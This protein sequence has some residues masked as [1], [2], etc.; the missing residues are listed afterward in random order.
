[1]VL[2]LSVTCTDGPRRSIVHVVGS[3][4][5]RVLVLALVLAVLPAVPAAAQTCPDPGGAEM[6]APETAAGDFSIGGHGWGHGVG[7]SQY[8]AY[9]A[10]TLGCTYTEI[11]SAYYPGTSLATEDET[12]TIRIRLSGLPGET[13]TVTAL[14]G[15]VEWENPD[16]SEETL[17]E[18]AERTVEMREAGQPPHRIHLDG[19]RVSLSGYAHTYKRGT[20]EIYPRF[21]TVAVLDL[22][23]YL[24]GLAEVPKLW[25]SDTLRAQVIAGRTYALRWVRTKGDAWQTDSCRCHI[26]DTPLHQAY[27]GASHE[28]GPGV[29]EWLAAVHGTA[30]QVLRYEGALIQALYSSSH[31]GHSVGNQ[32]RWGTDQLPYLAP[33][34]DSRWELEVSNPNRVWSV[35]VSAERLGEIADVGTAVSAQVTDTGPGGRIARLR[36]E[37]S[38]GGADL[39]GVQVQSRLG[40]R[41]IPVVVEGGADPEEVPPGAAEACP[42]D[43]VPDGGF[44]DIDGN[45]HEAA[46]NCIVE[47]GLTQ[48]LGDGRYGPGLA[49]TRD[50][51]ASFIA[52]LVEAAGYELPEPSDQGFTDIDGNTHAE[53]IN[54]LAAVGIVQGTTETSY[55]PRQEVRRDQMASFLVRAWETVTGEPLTAS[56]SHFEDTADSIHAENIDKAAEA[57]FARGVEEGRYAPARSVR[58][59]QMASFLARVLDGFV[60]TGHAH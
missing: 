1:M 55:S 10:A 11:L 58:R 29:A 31:G 44:D 49:V 32:F 51:M 3:T 5:M 34:D 41:A 9:G 4:P 20:I 33:V 17:D 47:W 38:A 21:T 23:E 19:T 30:G 24:Y 39:T 54:Q 60:A 6:P 37:G 27:T 40:L 12:E 8:G 59:D 35:G 43:G 42:E 14:D 13:I 28:S 45:T 50:Q 16:G 2:L 7:M 18:G 36:V 56:E 22:E 15:P 57:G 52:R 26:T 25:P 53:R 46:I 48:G